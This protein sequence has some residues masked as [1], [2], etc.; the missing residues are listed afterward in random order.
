MK[1][2]KKVA[3]GLAAIASLAAVS[4]NLQAQIWTEFQPA[5]LV[6]AVPYAELNDNDKTVIPREEFVLPPAD[7][8]D[9]DDGYYHVDLGFDFEYNGE[10]YSSIYINVNGFVTFSKYE[11]NQNGQMVMV[12]PPMVPAVDAEALFIESSS[13]PVNV[14]APFWGDH[15]YRNTLDEKNDYLASEISYMQESD[16]FIVQWKNLNVN[17]KNQ[18]S[19][20]ANFQLI[21]YKSTS[22]YSAQGDIE[23]CYGGIGGNPNSPNTVVVYKDASVGIKGEAE[24]YMNG[25]LF[26]QN[27]DL[28]KTSQ[29]LT[30][31]W[32]PSDQRSDAR[33]RYIAK[34]TN[35]IEEWWGDGDVDFS[36]AEGNIH[37]G[38]PQNRFVTIN[39]VRIIMKSVATGQPLDDA[40]RRQAYHGDVTHDGRYYYDIDDNKQ[41]I[42]YR[43]EVYSDDLPEAIA[44]IKQIRFE[45]DEHDAAYVLEYMGGQVSQ[46]P[47][48][49]PLDYKGKSAIDADAAASNLVLGTMS[50][51]PNGN[52]TIPI[53]VNGD[54]KGAFSTKFDIN[55]NV[56]D[57][58]VANDD[59]L[60]NFSTNRVVLV[61]ANQ[62]LS[63]DSKVCDIE[64]NINDKEVKLSGIRLN[65]TEVEDLTSTVSQIESSNAAMGIKM[66]S[67]NPFASNAKF[68]VNANM[69]N[70]MNLAIYDMLGNK[71]KSFDVSGNEYVWD[72]K[73]DNGNAVANGVYIIR[74]SGNDVSVTENVVLS[75]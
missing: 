43:S 72:G 22:T 30:N 59:M 21:I 38:Q 55:A 29:D 25:L 34:A 20:V 11:L 12:D 52:Y 7:E 32:Q 16:K 5:T 54:V 26:D 39:D 66:L 68:S 41:Y 57:V 46:L 53:Y 40:R 33:I 31:K 65:K 47:W 74:L 9:Y 3:V 36:K 15:Y 35:K 64:V 63:N 4:P 42:K 61:G 6:T 2:L 73:D 24:D 58:K 1:R 44:S 75:K 37:E 27:I 45:C 28:Q 56:V 19:S 14:L 71:V 70:D 69:T 51:L 17:D 10:V 49:H 60:T 8:V 48:I 50:K 18:P 67:K 23:F 13:Y 62:N